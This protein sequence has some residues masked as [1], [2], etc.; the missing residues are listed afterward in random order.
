MLKNIQLKII[1]IFFVIGIVIILGL[2]TFFAIMLSQTAVTYNTQEGYEIVIEQIKNL[3]N[4]ILIILAVYAVISITLFFAYH[5]NHI[6]YSKIAI[7]SKSYNS[8][9]IRE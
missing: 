9:I 1:L 2:G 7:L 6:F 5:V 8:F 4:I 3:R